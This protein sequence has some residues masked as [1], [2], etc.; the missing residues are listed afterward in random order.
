MSKPEDDVIEAARF[1][2]RPGPVTALDIDLAG[3]NDSFS[4]NEP[5]ALTEDVN[6]TALEYS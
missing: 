4:L 6:W 3:Y 5:S 2:M 1:K